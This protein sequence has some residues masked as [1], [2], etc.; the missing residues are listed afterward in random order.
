[1]PLPKNFQTSTFRF[2]LVNLAVFLA[3]MVVPFAFIYSSTVG[4]IDSETNAAIM[5]EIRG[6]ADEYEHVGRAGLVSF[7]P[8][9]GTGPVTRV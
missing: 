1:V 9:P 4:S 8:V 7:C 3:S 5:A 6:L 2:A